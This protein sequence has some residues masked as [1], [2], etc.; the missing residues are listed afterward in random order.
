M[1][2]LVMEIWSD[3]VGMLFPEYCI[4]C[5]NY[6]VKGEDLLCTQCIYELPKTG[7]HSKEDN[8]LEKSLWGRVPLASATAYLKY[9]RK[10]KVQQILHY[11]KYRQGT[12]LGQRLG[13][14][15]GTDLERKLGNSID[16]IIP[17]PL[18]PDKLKKRGY[19][20]SELFG[21]GLSEVLGAP[22]GTD[23]LTR[24]YA[25]ETQTRKKRYERWQNVEGKFKIEQPE[26]IKGATIL[27]VD[28]V[29]T[30]GATIEACCEALLPYQPAAIHVTALAVA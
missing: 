26:K 28:D 9:Q 27:L 15:Y 21:K 17:V 4:A 14:W 11:I 30:T 23:I 7:L 12:E 16:L 6:L 3:F 19:N 25:T 8:Y 10:G 13:V 1:H 20:Q 5:R 18:H 2:M 24:T 22:C 29:I